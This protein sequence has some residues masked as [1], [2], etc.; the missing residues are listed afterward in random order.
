MLE[1]LR[2]DASLDSEGRFTVDFRRAAAPLELFLKEHP[3]WPWLRLVQVAHQQGATTVAFSLAKNVLTCRYRAARQAGDWLE[4]GGWLLGQGVAPAR[5]AAGEVLLGMAASPAL[6]WRIGLDAEMASLVWTR[7]GGL[8]AMGSTA[9]SAMV[10]LQS[11]FQPAGWFGWGRSPLTAIHANLVQRCAMAPIPIEIDRQPINDADW[12]RIPGLKRANVEL[13]CHYAEVAESLHFGPPDEEHQRLLAGPSTQILRGASYLTAAGPLLA[14]HPYQ[15][16]TLC[17][18]VGLEEDIEKD[19]SLVRVRKGE[20][21]P[22]CPRLALHAVA[23]E[24]GCREQMF[25]CGPRPWHLPGLSRLTGYIEL[26]EAQAAYLGLMH[27]LIAPLGSSGSGQ[28]CLVRDG[29]MTN[30]TPCELGYPGLVAITADPSLTTD[31]SSLKIVEDAAFRKLCKELKKKFWPVIG[32]VR[33]L[34]DPPHP[35]LVRNG[36]L[37]DSYRLELL[38]RFTL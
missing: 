8:R 12:T 11:R 4:A 21:L 23:T 31:A 10:V 20:R 27:R 32:Q 28:L 2:G 16:R 9:D 37:A 35:T 3:A 38:T 36:A 33:S 18:A 14:E 29:V 25:L 1:G 17:L 5:S 19:L 7:E 13:T 30:A 22:P 6:E 24:D 15:C 26:E 34:L